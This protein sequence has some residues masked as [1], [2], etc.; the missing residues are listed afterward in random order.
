[1]LTSQILADIIYLVR[2]EIDMTPKQREMLLSYHRDL[3]AADIAD[4]DGALG[5]TN[6]ERVI[7][8]LIRK[9]YLTEHCE[10]TDAGK[11]ALGV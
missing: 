8:A 6:R 10:I 5:W 4:F 9:G 1:M 11:R 3:E 2:W 7:N